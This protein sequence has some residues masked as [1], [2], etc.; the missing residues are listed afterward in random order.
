MIQSSNNNILLIAPQYPPAING[1]GDYAALLGQ[2]LTNAGYTVHYAGLPQTSPVTV[3]PYWPLQAN[4]TH[5]LQLVQ[6]QQIHTVILN[7]SGYG[8]QHKGVPLWLVT[9]LTKV[10]QMG[11]KILIFFH[12]LYAN[13][14]LWTTAFW[15]HPLQK[16]IFR[17]LLA[18]A[19]HVFTSN[20]VWF[21]ILVKERQQ[22]LAY[23]QNI[24][25]FSNIPEPT[26][27][28]PWLNRKSVLIVFG[29]SSLR[30]HTYA[31]IEQNNF[32]NKIE[33]ESIWD[34]GPPISNSV[35]E[36]L[37]LPVKAWG[38]LPAEEVSRLLLQ[39]RYGAICYR[40]DL[41]GKSGIMAAYTAH[42]V[43][44]WNGTNFNGSTGEGLQTNQHY[45]TAAIQNFRNGKEI[46][47]N[48]YKWY[49]SRSFKAH[50]CHWEMA[51]A[52]N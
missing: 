9:A 43:C 52:E 20:S 33:V 8:Y 49:Q 50:V 30:A 47:Q 6:Q 36:K 39:V 7:Y 27:I 46:A 48:G 13:G 37:T 22:A 26:Q 5:L 21:D 38:I 51:L 32:L 1:L 2:G 44:V 3:Q 28:V 15:L 18:L 31:A 24:G 25:I 23:I 35:L 17:Q 34:V 4:G 41:L 29:G 19:N 12:E 14:P 11:V 40:D 10:K 16:K 42:G 45:I